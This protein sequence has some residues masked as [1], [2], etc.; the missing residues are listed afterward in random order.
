MIVLGAVVIGAV[1]VFGQ[2][3]DFLEA[4]DSPGGQLV[5][6][7]VAVLYGTGMWWLNRLTRFQRAAR[8]LSVGE[9]DR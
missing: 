3:T 2:G 1:V 6:T 9:L 4:Y 5:L 7:I 8:I